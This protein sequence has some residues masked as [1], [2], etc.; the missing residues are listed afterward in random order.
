MSTIKGQHRLLH[1]IFVPTRA[2]EI[3]DIDIRE[4]RAILRA[5]IRLAHGDEVWALTA[6]CVLRDV[7]HQLVEDHAEEVVACKG[8]GE[9]WRNKSAGLSHKGKAIIME[10]VCVWGENYAAIFATGE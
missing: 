7:D 3:I 9:H 1:A 2:V 10:T 5:T 8:H 4:N 6:D